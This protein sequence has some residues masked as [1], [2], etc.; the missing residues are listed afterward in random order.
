M[1]LKTHSPITIEDFMGSTDIHVGFVLFAPHHVAVIWI[2]DFKSDRVSSYFR[3]IRTEPPLG[4]ENYLDWTQTKNRELAL[5]AWMR[6]KL[7]SNT[8]TW[9][10]V[11]KCIEQFRRRKPVWS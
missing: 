7:N 8:V 6:R 4:P 11:N 9:T 10:D 1:I 2:P 3:I 5:P